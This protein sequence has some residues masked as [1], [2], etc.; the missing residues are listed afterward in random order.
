MQL[1]TRTILLLTQMTRQNQSPV[2]TSQT[3]TSKKSKSYYDREFFNV[4]QET[5]FDLILAANYL[6]MEPLVDL[7]GKTVANMI[8]G[9]SAE[10]IRRVSLLLTI[11][12]HVESIL[13]QTFNISNDFTPA[14]EEQIL[15]E[16]KKIGW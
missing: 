12:I 4:D 11:I 10:E 2:T 7:G 3:G 16:R 15:K 8:K 13:F 6:D 5:L 9:K 14:E 1:I